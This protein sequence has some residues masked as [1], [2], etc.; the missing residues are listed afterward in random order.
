[1]W[2]KVVVAKR[3]HSSRLLAFGEQTVPSSSS[4][5][6]SSKERIKKYDSTYNVPFPSS[7]HHLGP[8]FNQ[9]RKQ[10]NYT[11]TTSTRRPLSSLLIGYTATPQSSPSSPF[12][13][14]ST[15]GICS[16]MTV[17]KTL[18]CVERKKTRSTKRNYYSMMAALQDRHGVEKKKTVRKRKRMETFG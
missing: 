13:S 1:M 10:H 16:I 14:G 4:S 12:G 3:T 11:P 7:L 9:G 18:C 5:S 17:A 6:S 8:L 2:S 15:K